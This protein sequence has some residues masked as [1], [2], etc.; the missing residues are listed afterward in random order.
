MYKYHATIHTCWCSD[1]ASRPSFE[2]IDRRIRALDVQGIT[3]LALKAAKTHKI[4]SSNAS[5]VCMSV[6]IHIC[7]YACMHA[8]ACF[9]RCSDYFKA[10]IN[11]LRKHIHRFCHNCGIRMDQTLIMSFV[12]LVFS[13]ISL[14]AGPVWCVSQ[15]R[16]WSFDEWSKGPPG[17]QG[18]GHCVL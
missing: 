2:E 17:T 14:R 6:C 11:T 15:A 1:P 13:L 8:R 3:S 10:N 16:R 5:T 9:K 18:N 7:I 12:L 4:R